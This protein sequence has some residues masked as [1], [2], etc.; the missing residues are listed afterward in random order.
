VLSAVLLFCFYAILPFCRS[1]IL[2]FIR[3][4]NTDLNI[5]HFFANF[6]KLKITPLVEA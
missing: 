1:T 6:M 2:P 5:R 3:S 4:R